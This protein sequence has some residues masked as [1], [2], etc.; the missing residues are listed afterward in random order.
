MTKFP[1]R[2]SKWLRRDALRTRRNTSSLGSALDDTSCSNLHS[3]D[4]LLATFLQNP[5]IM[6]SPAD[7][8]MRSDQLQSEARSDGATDYRQRAR[9][10]SGPRGP[11]SVSTPGMNEIPFEDD[12]LVGGA[13]LRRA[14]GLTADVQRVR[15][16]LGESAGHNFESFL[17]E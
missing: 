10:S 6:S 9:S 11:P 5:V 2:K 3:I 17:N 12:Q 15:D 16:E 7:E 8:P 4:T 13:D 1:N 14:R